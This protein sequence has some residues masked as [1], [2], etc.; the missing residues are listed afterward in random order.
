LEAKL[1]VVRTGT[2]EIQFAEY[3]RWAEPLGEAIGRVMKAA[4]ASADNVGSVEL[5]SHGQEKLDY[6]MR[7]RVLACEGVRG[8]SGTGSIRLEMSWE[9]QPVGTNSTGIKRGGFA[10]AP[11]VWNGK[12]YGQLAL[13]LS[14]AF[15]GAG[16]R[17]AADLPMEAA[18][19]QASYRDTT[20]P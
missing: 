10:A 20:K 12:D 4:L 16:K 14:S 2:N 5:D 18:S 13:Q 8:E 11:T 15:A 19:A 7:L 17:L 9:I 1:M 6:E 3:D